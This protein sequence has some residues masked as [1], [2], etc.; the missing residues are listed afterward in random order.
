MKE[1][2]FVF[3]RAKTINT[4]KKKIKEV[5]VYLTDFS[6]GII[7][8][9][10][11][12]QISKN[13]YVFPIISSNDRP[14]IK[15]KKIKN[16]TKFINQNLKKLADNN[17]ITNDIST[18]W[19][20]HSFVTSAVRSGASMEFVS[21]ALSHNNLKTTQDYFAGFEDEQKKEIMEKLMIF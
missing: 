2:A 1:D 10:C 20:R 4:S 17:G 12:P 15:Y 14:E 11:T 19:A 6:K 8:K 9:Y 13:D 7:E 3:M 16:F 18:Y 21:E 5:R